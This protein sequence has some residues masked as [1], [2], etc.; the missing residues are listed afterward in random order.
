MDC[1]L[2]S[3]MAHGHVDHISISMALAG[4]HPPARPDAPRTVFFIYLFVYLFIF[5]YLFVCL[6]LF[7]YLFIYFWGGGGVYA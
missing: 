5:I 1:Y 3:R 2:A 4:A 6:F 7:I